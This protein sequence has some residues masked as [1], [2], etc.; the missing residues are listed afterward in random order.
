MQCDTPE[1]D[2]EVR[3]WGRKGNGRR[4]RLRFNLP[5]EAEARSALR[6]LSRNGY[7]D[8]VVTQRPVRYG[9]IKGLQ[10]HG[11]SKT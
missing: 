6:E 9:R 4:A 1:L 2:D 11:S 3:V 8:L 10:K 7:S 5:S